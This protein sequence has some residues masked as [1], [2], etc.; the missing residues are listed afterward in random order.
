MAYKSYCLPFTN[1][2]KIT[3]MREKS[4][5][6]VLLFS[7]KRRNIHW[8]SAQILKHLLTEMAFRPWHE[9]GY[10]EFHDRGV[11]WS[12]D[13]QAAVHSRGEVGIAAGKLRSTLFAQTSSL[14]P[15]LR[16]LYRGAARQ[17]RGA[18]I[19]VGKV[20][21]L[22]RPNAGARFPCRRKFKDRFA[23]RIVYLR[24]PRLTLLVLSR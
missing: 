4:R 5:A 21:A 12:E 24:R 14:S 7:P 18:Q 13:F 19:H 8:F 15:W 6:L 3:P 23:P 1:C 11:V 17:N 2:V 16:H 22:H 10:R 9:S 20:S